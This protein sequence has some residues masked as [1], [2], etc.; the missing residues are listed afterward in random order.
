[1]SANIELVTSHQGTPHITTDQ[2]KDLLAGFCGD[3]TGVKIFPQLD[4]GLEVTITDLLEAKIATGQ[5]LAGGYH[6]QNLSDYTWT[7]DT[8][9]VGYSRIDVLYLVIYEDSVTTVQSADLVYQKGSA[10]V[11]GTTGTEPSAPT[12]TNVKETF[13]LV[14]ADITDGAIVT[15]SGYGTNY[16]SNKSLLDMVDD[17]VTQVEENTDALNGVRF[18]VDSNGKYGYI[19]VGADTVTPFRNPTGTAQRADVLVNKTFSNATEENVSGTMLDFTGNNKQTVTPSGGTGTQTLSLTA[20]KHDSVV[21]DRTNVY[22][23]AQSETWASTFTSANGIPNY[24][25]CSN[26]KKM[27][28]VNDSFMPVAVT[29]KDK[30]WSDISV[31][32]IIS[33]ADV[34][35]PNNAKYIYIYDRGISSISVT[36]QAKQL[37]G[38]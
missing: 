29:F 18:G 22:N 28:I 3:I 13:K 25:E 7:L 10:Y 14:R 23:A 16:L 12:G 15:V 5:G 38:K 9:N 20:G 21:V 17:T 19:K 1:M 30:N 36:Y 8:E 26:I 6:F 27:T 11:N 35:F 4:D 34:E 32:T 2:V 24:M 33:T 37:R 31:Q